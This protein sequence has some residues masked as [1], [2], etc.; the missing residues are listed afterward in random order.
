VASSS[1][2]TYRQWIPVFW[3]FE[4]GIVQKQQYTVEEPK[5]NTD[6]CFSKV[7]AVTFLWVPTNTKKAVN[8]SMNAA[9]ISNI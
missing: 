6:L 4:G 3:A 2:R 5:Q 8:A 9:D 1:P 7:T